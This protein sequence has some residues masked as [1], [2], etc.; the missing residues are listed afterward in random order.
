M[1][2]RIGLDIYR[3]VDLL[4]S[5][6]AADRDYTAFGLADVCKP[7][8]SHMRCMLAPLAVP[9]LVYYQDALF[10]WSG[11]RLFEQKLQPALV[12]LLL[13]GPTLTQRGTIA[14]SV[15]PFAVL[16]PR[17]LCW[18]ERSTSYYARRGAVVLPSRGG[19]LL[20]GHEHECGRQSVVRTL[21]ED[22]ERVLQAVVWSFGDTSLIAAI[23]THHFP[24]FNKLPI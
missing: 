14:G 17:V 8:P 23:G 18:Q 24:Y 1:R 2:W 10:V 7:L 22:Q 5:K 11:C 12:N 13:G 3:I 6:Q 15:L 9:M 19:R 16:L 4:I 21:P 20:A